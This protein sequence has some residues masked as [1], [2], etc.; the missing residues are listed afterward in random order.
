MSRQGCLRNFL[1]LA[2][3][4]A[5]FVGCASNKKKYEQRDK[6]AAQSGLYCDFLNGDKSKEIEV[7][8]NISM[9]KKCD[10]DKNFSITNYKNAAEVHGVM[11]CCSIKDSKESP[12]VASSPVKPQAPATT[13]AAPEKKPATPAKEMKAPTSPTAEPKTDSKELPEVTL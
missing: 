9:A 4:T 2:L 5:F 3:T 8:L 11:Y 13:S 10:S 7:D 6:M 12:A 1:G